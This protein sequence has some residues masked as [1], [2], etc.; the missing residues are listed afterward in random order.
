MN[1]IFFYYSSIKLME[2]YAY[3][4]NPYDGMSISTKSIRGK[5]IIYEYNNLKGGALIAGSVGAVLIVGGLFAYSMFFNVTTDDPN[6]KEDQKILLF[7]SKIITDPNASKKNIENALQ[8]CVSLIKYYDTSILKINEDIRNITYSPNKNSAQN[9]INVEKYTKQLKYFTDKKTIIEGN[10]KKL[11]EIK[12]RRTTLEFNYWYEDQYLKLYEIIKE[13]II[14]QKYKTS[15]EWTDIANNLDLLFN[16]DKEDTRKRQAIAQRKRRERERFLKSKG[17]SDYQ[18][19]NLTKE[20][21]RRVM[22]GSPGVPNRSWDDDIGYDRYGRRRLP[23]RRG[24]GRNRTSTSNI[25]T[26]KETQSYQLDKF[27]KNKKSNMFNTPSTY[28]RAGISKERLINIITNIIDTIHKAP[29]EPDST[30]LYKIIM[31]ATNKKPMSF[32]KDDKRWGIL[33]TAKK[34]TAFKALRSLHKTLNTGGII[35]DLNPIKIKLIVES[36]INEIWR[37]AAIIGGAQAYSID[38]ILNK[39]VFNEQTIREMPT[40]IIQMRND[41][42]R[43]IKERY[44]NIA[45]HLFKKHFINRKTY[46]KVEQLLHILTPIIKEKNNLHK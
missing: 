26:T 33:E 42:R 24:F 37:S 23:D 9:K 14:N 10:K 5:K 36:N 28:R 27:L 12:K 38:V 29:N 21:E 1:K 32:L 34:L 43:R 13:S 30:K 39:K 20:D 11:E 16:R 18:I 41:L 7:T 8:Q 44:A 40:K 19:K 25:D 46:I 3:I 22:F 31:S 17:Y 15:A 45:E 4:T 35:Q 2:K 6:Q